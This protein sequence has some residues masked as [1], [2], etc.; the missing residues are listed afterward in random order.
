MPDP[1]THFRTSY[2]WDRA[3]KIERW[4]EGPWLDEPD[5][6]EWNFERVRCF[7]RRHAELG[8]WN[9]YIGLQPGHPWYGKEPD[10]DVHG[11]VTFASDSIA[12]GP[13]FGL[14]EEYDPSPTNEPL[15]WV[16]FDAAHAWDI[17]PQIEQLTGGRLSMP[18]NVYRHFR[19][20]RDE[21][22]GLARQAMDVIRSMS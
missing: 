21:V 15:W 14:P 4:G 7:I 5:V 16:G 6:C 3:A 17:I 2:V 8:C 1:N 9:G 13:R 12:M 20:M 11:G 10:A 19:Y 22:E 18:E